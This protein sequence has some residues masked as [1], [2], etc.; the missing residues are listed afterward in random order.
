M[1]KREIPSRE[2]CLASI[3]SVRDALYVLGGKWKLPL[4]AS[5]AEGPRRFKEIQ[6][7]LEDITPKVLSK[8]LRELEL[9]QLIERKVFNTV[10]VTV[11]YEVTDYGATISSVIEPLR[12]WGETHRKRIVDSMRIEKV[13][14]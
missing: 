4:M 5:L 11:T 1:V 8:E 7:A 3:V 14:G 10:P 13:E 12:A 6:R 9:N 2:V